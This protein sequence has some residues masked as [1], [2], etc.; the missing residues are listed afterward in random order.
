MT[1]LTAIVIEPSWVLRTGWV[2]ILKSSGDFSMVYDFAEAASCWPLLPK[3]RP[4]L[5]L[6]HIPPDITEISAEVPGREIGRIYWIDIGP[7]EVPGK[8]GSGPGWSDLRLSASLPQEEIREKLNQVIRNI[9]GNDLP[10]GEQDLTERENEVLRLVSRGM[11]NKE[12][13]EKMFI[14]P[15]TVIT[16][17]KNITRKLG[18]KTVA[19]LTVYAILNKLV[20][21]DEVSS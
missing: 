8:E 11:T 2:H 15:H 16:H 6:S 14:S 5:V 12:I 13:A 21:P 10:P 3:Y 20:S 4:D 9:S 1:D 18:I 17:R 7:G 19:G